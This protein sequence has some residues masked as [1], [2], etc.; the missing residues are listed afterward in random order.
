MSTPTPP[1]LKVSPVTIALIGVRG[2]ALALNL[3]GNSKA[4]SALYLLADAAEAGKDV[5]VHMQTVAVKLR[6]RATEQSDWEEVA[7]AIEE[8]SRRLNAPG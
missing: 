3:S 8:D 2:A 1:G 4:A 6:S 7:N 5:D